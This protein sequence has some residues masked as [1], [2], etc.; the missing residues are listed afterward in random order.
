LLNDPKGER[1]IGEEEKQ[2]REAVQLALTAVLA[3]E[4]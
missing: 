3:A 2:G 4:S 1:N